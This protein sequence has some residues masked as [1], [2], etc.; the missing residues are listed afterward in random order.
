MLVEDPDQRR[1]VDE[2]RANW[3]ERVAIHLDSD[4]YDHDGF[5][6]GRDTLERFEPGEV[7][8]VTGLDLVHLQCHFGHDTLSWARRGARVTGVDFSEPAI[9]AARAT[10][11][12]L[13]I[14]ARFVV[15]DVLDAPDA[16]EGATF[17]VVYTSHGVLVWLPD[18]DGWAEVVVTLLR[19]GGFVYLSEGHPITWA[20]A[21]DEPRLVGDYF[22]EGPARFDEPGT[23][24]DPDAA[25]THNVTNEWQHTLGDVVTALT[26][27]GLVLEFLHEHPFAV[28]RRYRW[29]EHRGD[30]TY[31]PPPGGPRIPLLFSLRARRPT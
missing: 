17:D 25:T 21:D 3:D 27:R 29:L 26:S 11:E 13:G 2:N 12:D 4:F 8:D 23:Y 20:V 30:G 28:W 16:L 1:R 7:G 9:A 5:L 14:A 22:Q 15:A 19:P 6:A 24:A 10:A 18:I 31:G